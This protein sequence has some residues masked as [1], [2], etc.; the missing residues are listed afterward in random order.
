MEMEA[1]LEITA[2]G[3]APSFPPAWAFPPFVARTRG[4]S[5]PQRVLTSPNPTV[6][7]LSQVVALGRLLSAALVAVALI[8][9]PIFAQEGGTV[10]VTAHLRSCAASRSLAQCSLWAG[11]AG[12]RAPL[13]VA[14]PRRRP[15][16]KRP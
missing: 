14:V 4:Q 1:P 10:L 2:S 9:T 11:V 7:G 12:S 6:M 5:L 15:L 3:G 16:R 8:S 13:D